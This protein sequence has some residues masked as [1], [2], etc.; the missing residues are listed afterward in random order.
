MIRF[1]CPANGHST[2]VDRFGPEAF[3]EQG[4]LRVDDVDCCDVVVAALLEELAPYV[5]LFG[6]ARRYL[7][8]CDEPLWSGI[9]QR[10]DRHTETFWIKNQPV[11]V[12]AMNCFT[13]NVFIS[14]AHFLSSSY[15]LDRASYEKLKSSHK[16]SISD[17]VDRTVA[18]FLSY[19]NGGVWDFTHPSGI[20]G[21]STLRSRIAL[22]GSVFGRVDVYGKDW[23]QGLAK[24]ELM[25]TA[26][27]DV[28]ES[29]IAEY[30]RYRF[31]LCFENTWAPYYVT[32]KIWH[33]ILA[34]CLPIYYAGDA[35][36]IYQDFPKNS[37]VD[38]AYME[39]PIQLF[40]I[41]KNMQNDEFEMR[42]HL[43][44]AVLEAGI[45]RSQ[46]GMRPAILQ[47]RMFADRLK[48]LCSQ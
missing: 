39:H 25:S 41:V 13:G 30:G 44:Q 11:V 23:P 48:S 15:H 12:D 46:S 10:I 2:I 4:L 22:E 6:N 37:F 17:S 35:H 31:A 8:W 28:F 7:V 26:S 42:M 32:E 21:L 43:C 14:N 33:A 24:K 18:G 20:R 47:L 19:R 9:Y 34:G 38:F 36:T 45:A 3:E 16:P 27:M 1:F 40:E 29:K 5:H